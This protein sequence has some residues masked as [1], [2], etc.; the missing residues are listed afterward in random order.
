MDNAFSALL[1]VARAVAATHS[2]RTDRSLCAI[3]RALA[4]LDRELPGWFNSVAGSSSA[5]TP[6]DKN[7]AGH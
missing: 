6:L 1:A 3:C 2:A 5:S 4:D 7:S